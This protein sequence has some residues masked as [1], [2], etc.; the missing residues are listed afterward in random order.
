MEWRDAGIVL[1]VRRHGEAHAVASLLTASHGR[2][3]GLVKGGASRSRRAQLEPGTIGMATWQ[4]RLEE[5]LGSLSFEP[6]EATAPDLL[7]DPDRLF[8][9]S[10]ACAMLEVTVTERMPVPDLYDATLALLAALRDGAPLEV[11]VRWELTLLSGLGFGLDLASCA[12]SGETEDLLYVSPRTGRAVSAAAAG[13]YRDR[14]LPLPQFLRPGQQET[15]ADAAMLEQGMALTG[16]FLARHA[17][18][19]A[20]QDR[21]E[22]PEARSLLL[23]RLRTP[24]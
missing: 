4:A 11:Y 5:Q 1:R 22:L 13:V 20:R 24:I 2:Q 16:Y 8:A 12:V 19:P 3:S 6:L 7:G 18:L 14:L 17:L 10:S 23:S 15:R 21:A 9:L